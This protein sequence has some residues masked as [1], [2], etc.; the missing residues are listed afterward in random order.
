MTYLRQVQGFRSS[1]PLWIM[2]FGVSVQRVLNCH[3]SPQMAVT[4][5][6]APLFRARLVTVCI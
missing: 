3:F 4:E 2:P 5:T 6:A 1:L